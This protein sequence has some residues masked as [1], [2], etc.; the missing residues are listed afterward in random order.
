MN[1]AKLQHVLAVAT[2]KHMKKAADSLYISQPALTKS[3][4]LLEEELGVKLFERETKPIRLTYAGE[5]FLED[6]TKILSIEK[7]MLLEMNSIASLKKSRLS[8]GVPGE[9]GSYYLP[10]LV[11]LYR[12]R[13]PLV[14]LNF[15]EGDSD[16]LETA[17]LN[18]DIDLIFYATPIYNERIA[19]EYVSDNL[20]VIATARSHPFCSPFDLSR[21]NC[22]NAYLIPPSLL[23]NQDFLLLKK[24]SGMRRMAE[25]LFERHGVNYH[26][27]QEFSRNETLVQLAAR[28]LGLCITSITAPIRLGLKDKMAYFSLDNPAM[29]RK[30]SY[31]YLKDKG[32]GINERNLID[33]TREI[34][35]TV[36]SLGNR[37]VNVIPAL[38]R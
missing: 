5:L 29:S 33:L 20:I 21:N 36:P 1:T 28:E 19:Y 13:Y 10:H 18:G 37:F 30:V 31:A 6:A 14:D 15:M 2:Y 12:E 7:H 11:S 34:Q 32:I 35:Q 16:T 23:N 22:E 26:I 38:Y 27:V 17:L 3:I 9:R 8:F 25:Y 24:G 4:N